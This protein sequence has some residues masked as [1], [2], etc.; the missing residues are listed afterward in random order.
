MFK[1]LALSLAM[2]CIGTASASATTITINLDGFAHGT[3]IRDYFNG[4]RDSLNRVGGD[5][6]GLSFNGG[7]IKHTPLGAYYTGTTLNINGSLLSSILGT[8]QYYVSFSAGRYDVD[9]GFMSVRYDDDSMDMFWISGNGN[10]YCGIMPGACDFPHHGTMSGYVAYPYGT[11]EITSKISSIS[12]AVNR[13]DN[14][15][16]H[17]Y[18]PGTALYRPPHFMGSYETARDIPEPA[19]VLLLGVGA[20]A[21]L[22]RRRNPAR[23]VRTAA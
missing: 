19:S 21:M 20:L 7:S 16:I 17:S 4:G 8:E 13:L 2:L 22:T 1:R 15:Q 3:E 12:F 18:T 5:N 6:Y 23:T 10:P 9:G 11:R 14:I